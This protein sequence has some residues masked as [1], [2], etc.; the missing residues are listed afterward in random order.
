V[1]LSSNEGARATDSDT[2]PKLLMHNARA[3]GDRP[4]IREKD[5][6]IW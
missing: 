3:R 6:G 5:Y 4:A 2:F 1:S